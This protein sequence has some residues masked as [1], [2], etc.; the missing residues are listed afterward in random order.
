MIPVIVLCGGLGSR[1]QSVLPGTPKVLAP[2]HGKPFLSYL[3]EQLRQQALLD[4]VLLSTGHLADQIS[5][6]ISEQE[7]YR[8]KVVCITE[9]E[10]MGTAGA[11][12]YVV[13]K[14]QLE[15]PFLVMNGDTWFDAP[16]RTLAS[17]CLIQEP[18]SWVV[19]LTSMR[20]ADRFGIVEFDEKTHQITAFKEK[21][22]IEETPAW[23]NAGVYLGWSQTFRDYGLPQPCSME[24]WLFPA[25][26]QDKKLYYRTFTD[27][28]FLDIGVPEDYH[29]AA[30]L[31]STHE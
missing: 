2:I 26:L 10:P 6:Y 12:N 29:L 5:T 14:A 30:K 11:V 20:H 3:L 15:G 24:Q 16:L 25:L 27:A 8:D 7:Q 1:L 17:D 28:T 21:Q 23:I 4:R 9:P 22:R 31:L 19:A 18:G 13:Q